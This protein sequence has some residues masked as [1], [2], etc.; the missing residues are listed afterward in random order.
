MKKIFQ[1]FFSML[2]SV[3]LL[4]IFAISIG[5]AT[6]LENDKGTEIAKNFIYNAIW[7]EIL[8]A[9][10]VVNLIGSV[11]RYKLVNKRK[12]SILLFHIAFICMIIGA[13][14]TRYTGFEGV[15]H[16]R[17]GASSNEITSDKT[18]VTIEAESN[19][20]KVEKMVNVLF[21]P[22]GKNNFSE[23]VTIGG[24]N[25]VVEQEQCLSNSIETIVPDEEGGPAISL[26]VMNRMNQVSEFILLPE[27]TSVIEG[28]DFGF[29]PN[30]DSVDMLFT[31]RDN[32]LFFQSAFPLMKSSM[33][34]KTNASLEPGKI[35]LA[36]RKIIYRSDNFL[37]VLK[38]FLP[39]AKKNLI[40]AVPSGM[41]APGTAS[42]GKD[43]VVFKISDGNQIKRINVLMSQNEISRPVV[44]QMQD[45][46]VSVTYGKL[47]HKLPFNIALQKFVI[48]RYPGSNS[49]SSFAS[50]ILLTDNEMQTQ[51][52]FRIYMNN[53][54]KYRGYRFFQ[55]S[56][57]PDER[58]TILS[59]SHD[60]WG[61]FI[62]Y[63][64][65]LLMLI[66]MVFTLF[67]KDSRFST[68]LKLSKDIQQKKKSAKT[69]LL[70]VFLLCTFG[71]QAGEFNV[72]KKEHL[73]QLSS[74]L[75]Q[76]EVQGRIEPFN[77]YS[78][79]LFRKISKKTS[80]GEFSATEVLLGMAT[81]PE[82]WKN[83]PIIKV[84]NPQ[85]GREMG[86]VKDYVSF[87]Q[88]FDF[89]NDGQY[90]LADLVEKTYQKEQT[91][92]N[93]Y[94]KEVLNVDERVNICYQIFSGNMLTIFP[95]SGHVSGKWSA[96]MMAD[97]AKANTHTCP[98]GG[99]G[100]SEGMDAMN[101]GGSSTMSSPT[102]T[103]KL[104]SSYFES[105]ILAQ[106]SGNWSKANEC[107]SAIKN[108]QFQNGGVNLP[109]T[110]KIKLEIVYNN[111][112]IFGKLALLYAI[113]GALLLLFHVITI[114]QSNPR[115]D[116][117]LNRSVYVF[118]LVFVVYTAGLVLRWYISGHAPWSNGYETIVFV[119]WASGLSGLLFVRRSPATLA[120]TS[121]LSAIA[122]FVAGMSWMNPEITNL[123]PVLKSYWLVLHVA[124]ITSSYGFFAMA[125][126]MGLFNLFLM[127]SRTKKNL[128]RLSERI[129]EF[130]YIIEMSLYIGLLMLTIGT[131]LGGVWA[132]E[133][134]GRY[135]GWDPKETWALV[136]ILIYAIV[137]HLR[138]VPMLNNQLVLSALSLLS[139]GTVIMTFFGVNYY[140]SGMHSY[141]QGTPPPV[142]VV[143]YII[144]IGILTIVAFA[145]LSERKVRGWKGTR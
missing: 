98:M 137:L 110:G 124:V 83:E 22:T 29:M 114:F 27:E 82:H 19:G 71:L 20:L 2:T 106:E 68:L 42:A 96:A 51:T 58:G 66:G 50:E 33:T 56:Y 23:S 111:L 8:L 10:L 97:S 101:S 47:P 119:G 61:T 74:L 30:K 31:I 127:I 1:A 57:D 123:V 143:L 99:M 3:V 73:N 90:R 15:M 120:I 65:Y 37:F 139:F 78:S 77:T 79:D 38:S 118:Q 128:N 145:I 85:L 112:N 80:Y 105:V 134:W 21:S 43:A 17:E 28:M 108:Y 25:I 70:P 44:C 59:V 117:I 4:S 60:Y 125:A 62:S 54:L 116:W 9:I 18:S 100:N 142:P 133:S 41:S 39:K 136:S 121:L 138:N 14:V 84:N 13:A 92:R 32:E 81:D 95:V 63:L 45:V 103:G 87:N 35:H 132:N 144:L 49:P 88:L 52:P 91:A 40:Q 72:T 7:F 129:Q 34:E 141:A 36:E 5:Y 107:L 11:F 69:F 130:S 135:W 140:L 48:E 94:D 131:F 53:I 104:L 75:I 126:L 24:K 86:A 12:W 67:S 76:D 46:K 64:G 89:D 16:I 115:M 6:F 122:L 55:S 26:L 113:L 93:K 109:S 102:S